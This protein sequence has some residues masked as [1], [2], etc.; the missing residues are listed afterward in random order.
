MLADAHM[1]HKKLRDE[2]VLYIK[3]QYFGKNALLLNALSD[4]LDDEGVLYQMPYVESTPAYKAV[5]NGISA[6]NIPSWLKSFFNDLA[7]K[8]LGVYKSPFQHQLD[9]LQNAYDGKDLFVSTGTGSGKTECFMWPLLAKMCVEAKTQSNTWS[10][11]GVR[12]IVMYPMNALVS[13]QISRL[14][15][16][17]GDPE[18][19]F[20]YSFRS[21]VGSLARRPQFGMYTGR[22][23][24]PGSAPTRSGDKKLAESLSRMTRSDDEAITAF[25]KELL[26]DGK[27]PAK[28]DLKHFIEILESGRHVTNDD[29]AELITRFEMQ[30]VCPD[31]LITNYSMLEYMLLRPR[32]EKIWSDTSGWLNSNPDNKLLYVIDEAHMY[33]G[34]SGGEVA[35]LIRRLF[36]KLGITRDRVQ[37]ILTTAS[38]PNSSHDDLAAVHEFAKNLTMATDDSF[39]Y[40]TG[41]QEK[42]PIG[43]NFFIAT[44]K[45][46]QYHQRDSEGVTDEE[47]TSINRFWSGLEHSRA[48]FENWSDAHF[49]MYR[50]LTNYA[51]FYKLFEACRGSACSIDELAKIFPDL[52][53]DLAQTAVYNLLA[54]SSLARNENNNV[55]FPI[56][57][58][59]LFRGLQGIYACTNPNCKHSKTNEGITLG[60]LFI[61]NGVYTCP[62]CGSAVYELVNDRRCGAL[63]FK[64]YVTHTT[65]KA[66]LW[67]SPGAFFDEKM[68]E[69]H[70]FISGRDKT[71]SGSSENPVKPCYLDTQSGFLDFHD[72]TLAGKPDIIKLYYSEYKDRGRPD[73]KTFSTCPHCRH[74]L[75]KTQL[76][77]FSTK[78]NQSFYNLIKAQF[79]AQPPVNLKKINPV[80]FPNQGRKVLLFSDSRQRAAKLAR[81]MSQ[82]SDN[83][84]V[85]QLFVLATKAMSESGKDL[86]LNN[87]YGYFVLEAVKR[88]VQ[89]FHNQSRDKFLSDSADTKATYQRKQKRG[90]EFKPELT[91]DNAPPM[92]LEHLI[93]LFC[94]GYNTLYDTALGWLE[95]REKN[96]EDAL[97]ILEDRDIDVSD[98]EFVKVFNAW[99]LD[100]CSHYGAIGHKIPDE[101]RKEV[102]SS[103]KG[104][105]LPT[106]WDFSK[107]MYDNMGWKKKSDHIVIAW[108]KALSVFLDS[109]ESRYYIELSRV[110]PKFGL[111]HEW[112]RCKQ[113]S[114]L[115]AFAIHGKC[116]TCGSNQLEKVN[117]QGYSAM[118]FW[119][120]PV[121]DALAGE[122][123]RVIDTEEHTAQLSY[124]DQRDDLWSRTEQY[125]MRF[126]DLLKKDE[127]PVDILSCTTTMEVGIDIGSLVAVGLRN[128]PPMRENYQQRA[129][130][131][132]RRGASL[133]T[134]VT[135]CEDGPHDTMYFTN[136]TP[137]FRGDPRRPWIDI[138][139]EKLLYRHMNMIAIQAFLKPKGQ[140][141]D[142]IDTISFFEEYWDEF[143]HYL[144]GFDVS[145]NTVLLQS[146]SME[147]I[148]RIRKQLAQEMQKLNEK[149]IAH[150]ELYGGKATLNKKTMLDA[151]YEEGIIPTY[152]FPKNVV[153]TFI[154]NPKGQLQYQVERGLYI[155]ISEYAPGR[156]IVVDKNTYQLG[157][158]YYYGSERKKGGFTTPA[159]SF[160]DDPNYV[161]T[162]F[163]CEACGWFG[164][165]DD[166]DN[167]HCP[168]CENRHIVQMLP[169]V[170][171]WGFAPVNGKPIASAQL[172]ESYSYADAPL[173]STLPN[174]DGLIPIKG[175]SNIQMAKR[176]N[177]RII[178]VNRG[179]AEKGFVICPDCGAAVPGNSASAYKT[180]RTK[181]GRPYYSQ[182][183]R[184]EC[185]HTNAVNVT[186]GFDFITDMLV[187]EIELDKAKINILRQESPWIDRASRSLAEAVRLQTSQLL[188]VEF[189]E[190]NTGYRLRDHKDK[191]YVDIY[192]YDSLSSGAGYSSGIALRINTLLERTETFLYGCKCDN[193]CQN[194]LKH[195]RNQNYH[196]VLDR[197][198]ALEL[199]TWAKEQRLA[200]DIPL[201]D[202]IKM[203]EP[204]RKVLSTYGI[205]LEYSQ[206][207]G[208]AVKNA[209]N[210]KQLY[211][212]PV[213]KVKPAYRS[214]AVWISNFEV[215]YARPY[216]IDTIRSAFNQ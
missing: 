147:L 136:P 178:M 111:K 171:P 201:Q 127:P 65:G 69:I 30:Q 175:F 20:L 202:Q 9:A 160:M 195:Y 44:D 187:L 114:E 110:V 22:T 95:P 49:W 14:R 210:V 124:K 194:C 48:P 66:F 199:L 123:I 38:M 158:L 50:N 130:R 79:N 39:I 61:T 103:Y 89:L 92:M 107:V 101:R 17:I 109:N 57:L 188:D 11:R 203:I 168:F 81:D 41:V 122:E 56:K 215:K 113:C 148:L 98:I 163:S 18:E 172:N 142:D 141:L 150:P 80:K 177:Q 71:Y 63:F 106:D 7:E 27:I 117:E 205:H 162:V 72:D 140:S 211:I 157:G 155:A 73:V 146:Y 83:Q 198:A 196:S 78:G 216:A 214:N 156:S 23:P 90:K 99:L 25:Y 115:T 12:T 47:L 58:H 37:F 119:R 149:R 2:L 8:E 134:I 138:Q 19:K 87:M 176:S 67:R 102:L 164:L 60:K 52:G 128:I 165:A 180:D 42:L 88:H 153:S 16:L 112:L 191:A 181:I 5:E 100:I 182:F 75:S 108:K 82:T 74:L 105:G 193:A 94:G 131:A 183:V 132:G 185:N 184:T 32:E 43:N 13:D 143:T 186:L 116:P 167:R 121:S 28:K 151:L 97:E 10:N 15:R 145:S 189:I 64:G 126:Q 139:S 213:M 133:S 208:L 129:G 207:D 35:L 206:V 137:M 170:R 77:S 36:H 144:N 212:Y 120:K 21:T 53:P 59:M 24:Y 204:L 197:Y 33:R 96:L 45:F 93:Y 29:D 152:S 200:D 76:T 31:I 125:E 190:L 173:Y 169:M 174:S 34:S 68:Y 179:P 54:I 55:L 85:M 46:L 84:A 166:L 159:K 6:L 135:F 192:M 154:S 209:G 86:S 104:F 118:E 4:K 1:I 91:F 62:D 70:L 3:S 51:P 40:L 161:K 26:K